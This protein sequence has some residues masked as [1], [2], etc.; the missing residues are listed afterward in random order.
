MNR[1]NAPESYQSRIRELAGY[2]VEEG[3]VVNPDSQQDF[4]RFLKDHPHRKRGMTELLSNG[5]FRIRW[6][7]DA[8]NSLGLQFLG[9]GQVEYAVLEPDRKEAGITGLDRLWRIVAK[10]RLD[11]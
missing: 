7:D 4:E 2:A 8:G 5:N 11:R 9:A 10:E 6:K 1:E 3:I